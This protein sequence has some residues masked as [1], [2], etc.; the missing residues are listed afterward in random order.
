MRPRVVAV[1]ASL[2][3]FAAPP[4]AAQQVLCDNNLPEVRKLDF[5][6]NTQFRDD[7]LA[8][9]IVTSP[10]GVARRLLRVFGQKLCFDSTEVQKD[11]NRLLLFYRAQ[12]F[13]GT[14][15][16]Q[17][18]RPSGPKAVHVRFVVREGRELLIDS[19]AVNGL[20]DVP[21][22]DRILRNLPLT[23]GS[24]M[25]RIRLDAM[26]DS[27]TRRLRDNGYPMAEVLRN[28][29]TDTARLRSI[30]WYDAVPGPRMRIGDI[31][32]TV[33]KVPGTGDRVGVHP[34]R[35]RAT[36]GIG[37]GD[38]FSER[39]LEGVKRGLYLTDAFQHVDVS[40]DTA[41][42]ADE[43][44]SLMNV[45]VTL[46]EGTL[47][48]ARASM[49]W[50]NYDCLRAQA[51]A[52][53]V[54]FL[55]ALRRVDATARVSRI[56]AGESFAAFRDLCTPQ[57]RA[58]P[59]SRALNYYLGATYSQPPLFGRRVFPSFTVFTERRSEFLTY[60][61]ETRLGAQAS[62]RAGARIPLSFSYQLDYGNT[63]A[64]QAYFCA[65]FNVCEP[66]LYAD[67][68]NVDRRTAVLGFSA[69]R[70]TANNLSDPS[71]GSVIQF[72]LRHA[73]PGVGSDPFIEFTRGSIDAAW[74]RALPGDGRFVLRVRAGSVFADQRLTGGQ[75][76]IPPQERLY[77]GG[78]NS[79]RGYGPNQLGSLVYRVRAADVDTVRIGGDRYLQV[80]SNAIRLNPDQPTGGDNVVVLNAEL[81][82]RSPLYPELIQ[83]AAFVDAGHVWN[84]RAT[85]IRAPLKQLKATPGLGVRV[86]S[87]IGPLRMD[88]ALAPQE[89]PRGPVYFID[90]R[91]QVPRG[92]I[93][94]NLGQVY[95]VSP[96]NR[97]AITSLTGGA[98]RQDP[99]TCPG[100]Y[101]PPPRT[102]LFRW[103]TFNFSIG[104]AF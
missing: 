52:S 41:S 13:R 2:L 93:N 101:R 55:G 19:L 16:R 56:G 60:L 67:L 74:Y 97:L 54:N 43:V 39:D 35:V 48:G 80:D 22:R 12:G 31:S 64:E 94:P 4:A 37:P 9:R 79:V 77:A 8:L 53:T 42:L 84:Q 73:S 83:L 24:R 76:F 88:V 14:A 68:A 29:D 78:P 11:V 85:S 98:V 103:V 23:V 75:R 66:E 15:V 95:C 104:Q 17:E 3:V 7:Q 82:L 70:S 46:R 59:L 92:V 30:V 58:D 81:R 5:T 28:I 45:Q 89:L 18:V 99:G 38:R 47:H 25:D 61:K 32:I 65:V 27:I 102:G 1:L 50:G 26:R 21:V 44:D 34:D 90:D 72:E 49:G 33:E 63:R 20:D 69:V 87:P 71:S 86:F 62:V 91:A 36:L 51:N 96:E 57:V 6:G 40:V 100:S 10:S